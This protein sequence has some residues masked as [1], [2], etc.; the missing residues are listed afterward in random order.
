MSDEKIKTVATYKIPAN[1]QEFVAAPVPAPGSGADKT[2][3]SVTVGLS[4]EAT[5][6]RATYDSRWEGKP[7]TVNVEYDAARSKRTV[8][9]LRAN[10]PR[11]PIANTSSG[12]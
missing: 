10:G 1:A 8:E 3:T 5:I 11:G 12:S 6:I 7:M 2:D 4:L 9:N